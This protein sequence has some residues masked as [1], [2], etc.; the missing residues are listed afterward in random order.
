MA[1]WNLAGIRNKVRRVTGRLTNREI[2]NSELDTYI[3]Q[4]YQYIFPADVKLERAHTFYEFV[5][6]ANVGTYEYPDGYTNFEPIGKINEF[7][8]YW[9]QDPNRFADQNPY[10]VSSISLGTGDGVTTGFSGNASSFPILPDS[11]IVA[12]SKEIFEDTNTTWTTSNIVLTGTEG[13]TGTINY[14]SGA[15]TVTFNTAP[16]SGDDVRFSYIQFNPGRPTSVLLYDNKFTFYPIPDQSYKFK[17]KAYAN[18]LVVDTNGDTQPFFSVTTDRPLLDEWGPAIAYGT[19]KAIHSDFGE[20]DAYAQTHALYQEQIGYILRR[21][22]QNLL[23][24]RSLPF[25]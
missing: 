4:F 13:G 24:T 5:T 2:S 16:S 1:I 3:N 12:D 15:V 9:Y 10:N 21:T 7:D 14:E 19:A 20:I 18:N 17:V 25:F 6:L 8:L 11:V 23:N 22:D